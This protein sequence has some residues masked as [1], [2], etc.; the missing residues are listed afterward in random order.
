VT[1][2]GTGRY[3]RVRSPG[4]GVVP[5]GLDHV[6]PVAR[7]NAAVLILMVASVT[8]AIAA[9]IGLKA[10]VPV[11]AAVA[12]V[13]SGLS[14]LRSSLIVPVRTR[15][16]HDA[17]ARVA[18]GNGEKVSRVGTCVQVAPGR[19]ITAAHVVRDEHDPIVRVR[20]EDQWH[21]AQVIYC[22]AGNDLAVL[23]TGTAGRARARIARSLPDPGSKIQVVGWTRGDDYETRVTFEYVVQAPCA[24]TWS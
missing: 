3:R 12:A 23:A 18:L 19:W 24:R 15:R 5:R 4:E 22:D 11:I 17:T 2:L 13:V 7:S 14:L 8:S 1:N 16:A 20:I 21:D 6:I 10:W 9:V